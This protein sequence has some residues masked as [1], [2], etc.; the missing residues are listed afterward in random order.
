MNI[1]W[2][3]LIIFV[4]LAAAVY[5]LVPTIRWYSMTPKARQ[6]LQK[7]DYASWK[8][9]NAGK[10][11][12]GLDLQGGVSLLL[13]VDAASLQ[14]MTLDKEIERINTEFTAK[15]SPLRAT[16]SENSTTIVIAYPD[17]TS[18]DAANTVA[19]NS[20]LLEKVESPEGKLYYQVSPM[21][22]SQKLADTVE[23][24]RHVIENRVNELGLSETMVAKVGDDK[25]AVQLPGETDPER[26]TNIIRRQAFL[27]FKLVA[28]P[29]LTNSV[30]DENGNLRPG[31]IIPDGYELKYLSENKGGEVSK[32]PM[33]IKKR[34]DLTGDHIVTARVG[35]DSMSF[36]SPI[37]ELSLDREGARIFERVTGMNI[38]KQLAIV[39][40]GEVKSAP[41]I[42]ERIPNGSARITGQYTEQEA[43]DL[44]L[45]LKSGALPAPLVVEESRTVGP[46]LGYDS[47]RK[48]I[49][50]AVIGC[51][52]VVLFMVV[53][54]KGSGLIADLALILNL[55]V[56]LAAMSGLGATLTVPGIAGIVLTIGMAVDANVLI[57]ER[58]REEL[59][60][61][62]TP[63][64]AIDAGYNRAFSA[65]LDSNVTT[66]IAAFMLVQ[67]G[68]SAVKG[69]AITLMVGIAISMF[70]AILVT[71]VIFDW[72]SLRS[73]FKKLSI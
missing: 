4:V 31:A 29:A 40:D 43:K 59:R 23:Q 7:V 14:S 60:A 34:A 26:A 9:L 13:R 54:Y 63:R 27:E 8:S 20:D 38:N 44:S 72:I 57:F 51:L 35:R 53:Y 12:L 47:I 6:E 16:L 61:G 46:T 15:N 17:A 64:A 69:F 21:R 18:R 3:L 33:L 52:L 45:V 5:F 70:T 66:I 22:L 39:L 19:M 49:L 68:S 24:A 25:I 41:N 67:F 42:Q 62:K 32:R 55:I 30:V 28:D 10:L 2:K 48:G 58:I 65:I 37:V 73:G 56:L 1:K 50:S 71:R 36:G 11:N